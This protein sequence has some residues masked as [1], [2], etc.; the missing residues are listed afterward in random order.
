VTAKERETDE[1]D[2]DGCSMGSESMSRD[3]REQTRK[4]AEKK[5]RKGHTQ[6]CVKST[7]LGG[8]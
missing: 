6:A 8:E 2:V 7:I 1:S 5:R 3:G 4:H